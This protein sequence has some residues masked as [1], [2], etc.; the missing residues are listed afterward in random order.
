MY[1]EPVEFTLSLSKRGITEKDFSQNMNKF[2]SLCIRLGL[3]F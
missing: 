1:A 2:T 3:L